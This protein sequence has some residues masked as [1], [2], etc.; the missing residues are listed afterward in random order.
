VATTG[1]SKSPVPEASSPSIAASN[2]WLASPRIAPV[3]EAEPSRFEPVC[4]APTCSA[5]AGEPHARIDAAAADSRTRAARAGRAAPS[6]GAVARGDDDAA[7]L[8]MRVIQLHMELCPFGSPVTM[9]LR[10]LRCHGGCPSI[11]VGGG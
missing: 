5:G 1:A 11:C 8:A 4:R 10:T 7:E 6:G 9:S 2:A 3:S